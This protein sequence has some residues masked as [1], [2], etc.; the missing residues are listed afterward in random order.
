VETTPKSSLRT[1]TM[2]MAETTLKSSLKTMVE[3]AMVEATQRSSSK[4]TREGM[5]MVESKK[6]LLKI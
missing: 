2:D 3:M 4:I 6:L 1:T 5:V